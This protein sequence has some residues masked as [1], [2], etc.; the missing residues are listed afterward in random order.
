[1]LNRRQV[2]KGGSAA[3]MSVLLASCGAPGTPA[4]SG[5]ATTSAAGSG[6]PKRGGTLKLTQ[7]G[8]ITPFEFQ[9]LGLHASLFMLGVFDTLVRY[10]AQLQP[11]PRLAES[12]AWN[13]AN[14][15]LTLKLRQG[16]TY[17]T[18]RPFTS[19]DVQFN[20]ERVRDP[21]FGSQY[22]GYSNTITQMNT[23]DDHTIVLAFDQP[24]PAIFDMFNLLAML[25]SA[26]AAD[27]EGATQVIGTGP[28]KWQDY[29]PG[30]SLTLVR[31]DAYWESGKP[32][33][34]RV[35]LQIVDD[36][37]SMVLNVESGQRD[38]A[39]QVL[40]QDL[41]RLKNHPQVVPE[42]SQTGAQFYYIGAVVT[43]PVL[44]D[45]RVRQAF[46]AAI[47]RQ[48]IA[49]T[50]VF[51]L[52]APTALPWP[53]TSPAYNPE[54]DA[55]ITFDL[56]KAKQLFDAAGVSGT[57][58]T[59]EANSPETLNPKIAQI[60]QAD[61]IKIGVTLDVQ[62][63]E[64]TV[65]QQSLNEGKFKQ[66]F[67]NT[68]GFSNYNPVTFFVTAFPVR[69]SGN[70]SKFDAPAYVDVIKQMQ[71]EADAAKLTGLYDQV[72]TI[73]LDESFNMPICQAPQGW[74]LQKKVNG[75]S[76]NS[77]NYVYLENVWLNQ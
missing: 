35:E 17:H 50:L 45:K 48:R 41:S 21:K 47:D 23:P 77:G 27:L 8:P 44:G 24:N 63:L 70:A 15:E 59:L 58:L 68:L 52:T 72:N 71:V 75:F 54:L 42:I 9:Q 74:V 40:A 56:N 20:F 49:E 37:Q 55:S 25:D 4:S 28:F 69:I 32:Y 46:N 5:S 67:G 39:W 33:L 61:L 30:T 14:T 43:D 22:R 7:P 53:K 60:V 16:V 66:F 31:N 62:T 29:A 1:M 19:K 13:E 34:D 36:K 11:Q 12:W 18:G 3:V 57:T 64:N 10:D 73:L 26:T 51:G 2:L 76:Y 38:V 6:Q 65:F